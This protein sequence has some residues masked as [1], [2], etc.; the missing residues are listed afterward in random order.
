MENSDFGL[1][2]PASQIPVVLPHLVIVNILFCKASFRNIVRHISSYY[3]TQYRH[4]KDLPVFSSNYVYM[5]S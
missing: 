2:Y 5:F 4:L 3:V 1:K